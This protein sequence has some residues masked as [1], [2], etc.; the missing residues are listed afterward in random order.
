MTVTF[1]C[2]LTA[3]VLP[4]A[5]R[6]GDISGIVLGPITPVYRGNADGT[7]FTASGWFPDAQFPLVWGGKN[8]PDTN[9]S[10][11]MERHTGSMRLDYVKKDGVWPKAQYNSPDER[12]YW[13]QNVYRPVDIDPSLRG[14]EVELTIYPD[15]AVYGTPSATVKHVIDDNYLVGFAHIEDWSET[16]KKEI[17][18]SRTIYS[19][20][21][22]RNWKKGPL[23]AM[24]ICAV[25][26]RTTPGTP[27]LIRLSQDYQGPGWK[28]WTNDIAKGTTG[29]NKESNAFSHGNLYGFTGILWNRYLNKWMVMYGFNGSHGKDLQF[30]TTQSFNTYATE[31]SSSIEKNEVPGRGVV[32]GMGDYPTLLGGFPEAAEYPIPFNMEIGQLGWVYNKANGGLSGRAIHFISPPEKPVTWN[33]A[34][35]ASIAVATIVEELPSAP[36]L[37]VAGETV[38]G[39]DDEDGDGVVNLI[40][41]ATGTALDS[42]NPMPGKIALEPQRFCF[43]YTRAASAQAVTNVEWSADLLGPWT[44]EG[45]TEEITGVKNGL[46]EICASLPREGFEKRFMRLKATGSSQSLASGG[47]SAPVNIGGGISLT[48]ENPVIAKSGG[49]SVWTFTRS[50]PIDAARTVRFSVTGTAQHP[51]D[52]SLSGAESF[53]GVSGSVVIP[54]SETSASIAAVPNA[55]ATADRTIVVSAENAVHLSATDNWSV[56]SGTFAGITD[57][58]NTLNFNS[59]A[60]GTFENDIPVNKR[61]RSINF[62]AASGDHTINGNR[63]ELE[64][65]T[66]WVSTG[67]GTYSINQHAAKQAVFNTDIN[68]RSAALYL[69]PWV[70][71]GKITIN[72]N[73]DL[74]G[75]GG[76]VVSGPGD[77]A[78]NGVISDS[79]YSDFRTGQKEFVASVNPG[80]LI[81]A[82]D[83]TLTLSGDNSFDGRSSLKY[84]TVR[85]EHPNALKNSVVSLWKHNVLMPTTDFKLGGL[86]GTGNLNLA[87]HQLTLGNHNQP[88]C[89]STNYTGILSGDGSVTKIDTNTQKLGAVNRHT[90]GTIVKGGVL[91]IPGNTRTAFG[92]GVVGIDGGTLRAGGPI[93]SDNPIHVGAAGGTL[94]SNGRTVTF[95]GPLSGGG[96]LSA[97]GTGTLVLGNS[98]T[99]T[100]TLS[101]WNTVRVNQPN[102]FGTGV[103]RIGGKLVLGADQ[104]LSGLTTIATNTSVDTGSHTL[105]V[106]G[107]ISVAAGRTF[108][109]SGSGTLAWNGDA[110]LLSGN[111]VINGGVFQ[112]TSAGDLTGGNLTLNGANLLLRPSGTGEASIGIARLADRRLTINGAAGLSLDKGNADTLTVTIGSAENPNALSLGENSTVAV[113][114]G[115]DTKLKA[116]GQPETPV[117]SIF[118]PAFLLVAPDQS[119]DFAAYSSADGFRPFAGY[120]P[121]SGSWTAATGE[122]ANLTGATTLAANAT[123]AGLRVSGSNALTL[124]SRVLTF[125]GSDGKAGLIL[126][127]GSLTGGAIDFGENKGFIHT[128]GENASI[129]SAIRGT[130]GVVFTGASGTRVKLT[131]WEAPYSNRLTVAGTTLEI[132]NITVMGESGTPIMLDGGGTLDF[133]DS[134]SITRDLTF[135][136]G[137][138]GISVAAG[139]S[140][141]NSG[142]FSGSGA[143]R[144]TG[145][146]YLKFGGPGTSTGPVSVD[147]GTLEYISTAIQ[148]S[149]GPITVAAGARVNLSYTSAAFTHDFRIAGDG[150]NN[151]GALA[152]GGSGTTSSSITLAGDAKIQAN[153][154][155]TFG[156]YGP[157]YGQG[158]ALKIG[159][160]GR[161]GLHSSIDIENAD[162]TL[163]QSPYLSVKTAASLICENLT[164]SANSTLELNTPN[165]RVA[166]A[167]IGGVLKGQ[168]GRLAV[169]GTVTIASGGTIAG[170]FLEDPDLFTVAGNLILEAGSVC[171]SYLEGATGASSDGT[172]SQHGQI[173]VT[174]SGVVG[175][176]LV[177]QRDPGYT[178]AAGD[179]IFVM[180]RNGGSGNFAEVKVID[181]ATTDI[182]DGTQGSTITLGGR[183]GVIRYNSHSSI[184]LS[185]PTSGSDISIKFQ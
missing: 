117:N 183:T 143:F 120:T 78:I 126:N 93:V 118:S 69:R 160:S 36:S 4:A 23:W 99:F 86:D 106:D 175:G 163:E 74:L 81:M 9:L 72:G 63:I 119:G 19:F 43:R 89:Y 77:V 91:E 18:G 41:H 48:L 136:T 157:I 73:V 65:V 176:T 135:G 87:A 52:F 88:D 92:T 161:F 62:S 112:A 109:K 129:A 8:E 172:G 171:H 98:G 82:G 139:K 107:P 180:L 95:N 116:A 90:G 159:G 28:T 174:G 184:N 178:P 66:K 29:F 25:D 57:E 108:T 59:A 165:A 21:N 17:N 1:R 75:T 152:I 27:R 79:G 37:K 110:S 177:L 13:I 128:S 32:A 47:V 105:T 44:S 83:G 151:D 134:F 147:E 166:N 84:G 103:L 5:V 154:G 38:G 179:E 182:F 145:A 127:N 2:L 185:D 133:T 167:T 130:G 170:G 22:G 122:I 71:G 20:D 49:A 131:C 173:L 7:S 58:A 68:T 11:W 40:E 10:W 97:T 64:A 114:L 67:Y 85:L 104:W 164:T 158:N 137:G 121:R 46:L 94:D 146:G 141:N 148:G 155:A 124:T 51:A 15:N 138:A 162:L 168:K 123:I 54:A 56:T 140:I 6:A 42:P 12:G 53:D 144:K 61:V 70:A 33:G 111:L 115:P 96:T 150:F 35:A 132:P 26:N 181:G 24:G 34:T 153:S 142:T 60:G 14:T 45:I 76:V 113:M 80:R 3:A 101:F 149:T 50:G 39:L 30:L 125:S 100:G 102:A 31:P 156:I 55:S 16:L 169:T